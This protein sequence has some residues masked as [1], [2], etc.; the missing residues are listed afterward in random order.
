MPKVLAVEF[1]LK[2]KNSNR[3]GRWVD[4]ENGAWLEP[5]KYSGV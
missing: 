1:C 2:G 5:R 3:E 4:R